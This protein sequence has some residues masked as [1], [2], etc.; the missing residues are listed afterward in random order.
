MSVGNKTSAKNW[1]WSIIRLLWKN[2][3]WDSGEVWLL[4][5]HSLSVRTV[6][7]GHTVVGQ[8]GRHVWHVFSLA[9]C[10]CP[11]DHNTPTQTHQNCCHTCCTHRWQRGGGGGGGGGGGEGKEEKKEKEKKKEKEE[12][13]KDKIYATISRL[14]S[15]AVQCSDINISHFHKQHYIM[16]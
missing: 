10:C 11:H 6:H 14:T 3:V 8:W 5:A 16:M 12:N 7:Q 2:E 13:E 9:A 1:A 15:M 4:L